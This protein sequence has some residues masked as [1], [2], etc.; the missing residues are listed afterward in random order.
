MEEV[1]LPDYE[2]DIEY[3]SRHRPEKQALDAGRRALR[4]QVRA[5]KSA[6]SPQVELV[7]GM[8]YENR[9]DMASDDMYNR[10]S[11]VGVAASWELFT[12]G[13]RPGL[14]RE[15]AAQLAALEESYSEVLLN[16]QSGIRQALENARVAF[17]TYQRSRQ[18]Q[19]LTIRIRDSVEKSYK[20]GMASLTRLNEAQTDLTR[21][22]G[23]AA[24][25]RIE[26]LQALER[27][28]A[29]TGRILE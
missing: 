29:E 16:I 24:L 2:T 17:D 22:S 21:A 4:Q 1:F 8:D 19:D 26:Y 23:A 10:E 13:R 27:L 6:Y 7:A 15:T 20:A 18:A 9:N 25:S 14:V 5:R 3:A 28:A 12:G 11:Y